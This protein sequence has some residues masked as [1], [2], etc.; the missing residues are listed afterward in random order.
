MNIAVLDGQGGGLGKNVISSL[1][2]ELGDKI[3]IY[4]LGTNNYAATTM[5]K[6]G[7]DEKIY[8]I[9]ALISLLHTKSYDC[10]IGPIGIICPGGLKGEIT[11][12]LAETIFSLDCTK[13]LIPL[14]VHGIYIPGV[15][16]YDIKDLIA[17][18]VNE[19]KINLTKEGAFS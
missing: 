18:I 16:D 5:K 2:K 12:N 7:A 8:G 13:Y 4:A 19:I 11:S 15:K 14:K 1:R 6:A 9:D 17:N 3:S 10:I